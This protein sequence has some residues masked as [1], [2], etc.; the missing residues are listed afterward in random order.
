MERDFYVSM[1]KLQEVDFFFRQDF[2]VFEHLVKNFSINCI[3]CT[4]EVNEEEK[5]RLGAFPFLPI[6]VAVAGKAE[7]IKARIESLNE[8]GLLLIDLGRAVVNQFCLD[9]LLQ[10][11]YQRAQD[12]YRA[13]FVDFWGFGMHLV[14]WNES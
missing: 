3:E 11:F 10:Q 12:Y 1:N 6:P 8:T 13:V 2:F 4:C 14:Q 7:Q 9:V 5:L